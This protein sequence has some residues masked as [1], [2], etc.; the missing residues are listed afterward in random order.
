MTETQSLTGRDTIKET[1][2][3]QR[4]ISK[5]GPSVLALVVLLAFLMPL[6]YGIS[7]SLKTDSQISK[8]GSPAI[9]PSSEKTFTYEGKEYD[10][11]QVPTENGI[12][13]WALVKK[14]REQSSFVDP[15]NPEAGLIEWEG[16]WRTLERVWVPDIQ[17]SNYVDAWV[18]IDFL[19]LLGNTLFYAVLSTVGA[20]AS[21]TLVAYGFARFNFPFKNVLFGIVMA[22]IIL[23]GAVTL[24]PRYAFFNYIGWVGTWYPLIVPV[25]FANAYNIFLLRQFFLGIPRD[26]DEAATI[27]GA[28][29]FR[30]F[31]SIILPNAKPALTAVILFHFF[32]AWNDF[33]EP[34]IYLAGNPDK[35]P[36]TV[37]LT[38]FNNL[39][40]QQTNLI[41]AVSII[42]L[43]IPLV[44]FFFAQ[45]IFLEG[46]Q[47]GGAGVDK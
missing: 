14:G 25:Y 12:Q 36:I 2:R 37:G 21:S 29:A 3:L 10:V 15:A 35:F 38:G 8:T 6:G 43:A 31:W 45:R 47:I 39:Y 27:D 11:Y 4:L 7:T 46:I 34:L 13:E 26:L 5:F 16:R 32:F 33:L 22:T 18:A 17:W 40:T 19:K 1:G 28:G 20:V 42:S 30:T 23:P 41:M 9:I 44:V 24:I